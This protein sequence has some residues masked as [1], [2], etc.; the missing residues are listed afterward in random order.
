MLPRGL[1]CPQG[2]DKRP[3]LRP[4]LSPG[5]ARPRL[6]VCLG[7]PTLGVL[8]ITRSLLEFHPRSFLSPSGGVGWLCPVTPARVIRDSAAWPLPGSLRES[9]LLGPRL[10][11]IS[12]CKPVWVPPLQLTPSCA[13]SRAW[14]T[15]QAMGASSEP[16]GD[17]AACPAV[18]DLPVSTARHPVGAQICARRMN[19][20]D[21]LGGA[22][23]SL[24]AEV[25]RTVSV[26]VCSC[27][28]GADKPLQEARRRHPAPSGPRRATGT[29]RRRGGVHP[30]YLLVLVFPL[31]LGVWATPGLGPEHSTWFWR[32]QPWHLLHAV[33]MYRHLINH[34]PKGGHLFLC[35][36][37]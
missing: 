1:D 16:W 25:P 20:A 10:C 12:L 13:G 17:A 3:L 24:C 9:V 19:A 23:R 36:I 28:R 5:R 11:V 15:K 33:G 29:G 18:R 6:H 34:F 32:V 8:S 31:P 37:L 7:V 14:G 21:W 26:P 27:G 4:P 30:S 2:V 22:V 35:L